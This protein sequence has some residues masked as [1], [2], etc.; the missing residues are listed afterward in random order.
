MDVF[1]YALGVVLG[2]KEGT[3]E[4]VIYYISKNLQGA[5][6]NYVIIE[7]ELLVFVLLVYAPNK[8]WNSITSYE[9]FVYTDQSAIKYLMNKLVIFGRLAHWLLLMQE[10]N[11]KII[12]KPG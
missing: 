8:F 4:H 10:F 3:I 12:D 5:K 2:Q 1:D 11:V 7:K 6:M 9:V